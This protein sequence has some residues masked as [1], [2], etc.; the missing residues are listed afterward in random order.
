LTDEQT[1]LLA[2]AKWGA[3]C[4]HHFAG[5]FSFV[6]WD[7]ASRSLFLCAD[8]LGSSLLCFWHEGDKFAFAPDPS[9]LLKLPCV[10]RVLNRAKLASYATAGGWRYGDETL[11]AGI[12]AVPPGTCLLWSGSKLRS[13][14]YWEP[15]VRAG[16]VPSRP[17]DAYQALRELIFRSIRNRTKGSRSVAVWLSG[18]LD[19]SI[20]AAVA[21]RCLEESGG[22]VIGLS[23]VVPEKH[24]AIV[25][26]E[27]R[28]IEE[29]RG[30]PNIRLEYVEA[31][32]RGPFDIL[33]SP[34]SMEDCFPRSSRDFL[35]RAMNEESM[36][37]GANVVMKGIF[38]EFSA[39]GYGE[40]YHAELA[41]KLRW[42]ELYRM[43]RDRAAAEPR[44]SVI[45]ASR[46]IATEF[47][48]LIAPH[49]AWKPHIFFTP[50]FMKEWPSPPPASLWPDHRAR[51]VSRVKSFMEKH[52]TRNLPVER[53]RTS[54]PFM[55]KDLVEFCISAPGYL[56]ING[57]CTRYMAR[58]SMEGVLP[59][60]L[61]WRTSKAPFSPDYFIRYNAQIP[62]ARAFLDSIRRNDPVR[63]VVDVD[64][65]K[66]LLA[67]VD[68]VNGT[69]GALGLPVNLYIIC[70]LR[71]FS[72][73]RP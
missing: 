59:R 23:A 22:Q 43:L 64:H 36:R 73:F 37:T 45:K 69:L 4:A 27:R 60:S 57:A 50:Q 68:P 46:K 8:H 63:T 17:D 11:H 39:T 70:F 19:S 55:D 12:K 21:S 15:A 52:P 2:Y 72:E 14:R 29:F 3:K 38:G 13:Y 26:D 56:K 33:D 67:P 65:L 53:L 25:A 66:R 54:N 32:G 40:G 62:K 51:Q 6:I 1:V 24:S 16:L 18:G 10:P 61:Q 7:S 9:T 20:I 48:D 71:Q 58:R 31:S 49:R 47:H 35:W 34:E 30:W 5:E 44:S 42:L 41:A 28:F